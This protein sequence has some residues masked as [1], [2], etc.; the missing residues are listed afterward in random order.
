MSKKA[1]PSKP[2][3]GGSTVKAASAPVPSSS[4]LGNKVVN[5]VSIPDDD[6]DDDEPSTNFFSFGDDS[7][8]KSTVPGMNEPVNSSEVTSSVSGNQ[9]NEPSASLEPSLRGPWQ[10]PASTSASL[11]DSLM[12]S[13]SKVNAPGNMDAPLSFK[14]TN[15]TQR[16]TQMYAGPHRPAASS[17]VTSASWT[18]QSVPQYEDQRQV[19]IKITVI[20]CDV[21]V[22]VFCIG[23]IYM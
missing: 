4:T 10:G 12:P 18:D 15:S 3:P 20:N 19:H 21:L 2:T 13:S 9:N 14:N 16:D 6:S 23:V 7:D 8:K 1:G 11:L 22:H 17:T 5:L